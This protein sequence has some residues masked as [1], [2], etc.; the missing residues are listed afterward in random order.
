M[1]ISY[2]C[3]VFF[4]PGSVPQVLSVIRLKMWLTGLSSLTF[5]PFVTMPSE[6]LCLELV[7]EPQSCTWDLGP[8]PRN[9]S[10]SFSLMSP[11][12]SKINGADGDR[13]RLQ[14]LAPVHI[15]RSHSLHHA[16]LE[17]IREQAGVSIVLRA[18]ENDEKQQ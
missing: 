16:H 6:L 17:M 4:F 15:E 10:S 9:S 13:L 7:T 18:M 1:V 3:I 12:C 2:H 8:P 5:P 11:F 14:T